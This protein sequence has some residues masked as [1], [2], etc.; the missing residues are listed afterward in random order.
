MNRQPN[1]SK[2]IHDVENCCPSL[3]SIYYYYGAQ[4][5]SVSFIDINFFTNFD[6]K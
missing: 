3:S 4:Q 5:L 2:D 6:I 1:K